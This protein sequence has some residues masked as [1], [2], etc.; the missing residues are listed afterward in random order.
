MY[1]LL[2]TWGWI[3]S[4]KPRSIYIP[5]KALVYDPALRHLEPQ[6]GVGHT[7]VV[8]GLASWQARPFPP[9]YALGYC[10]TLSLGYPDVKTWMK[11]TNYTPYDKETK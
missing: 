4:T 5:D 2:G 10:T 7:L 8:F 1:T 3:G 9:T 11:A 6:R